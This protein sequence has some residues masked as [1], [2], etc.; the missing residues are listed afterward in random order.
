MSQKTIKIDKGQLEQ[1]L[2]GWFDK[3]ADQI[4]ILRI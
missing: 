2:F 1:A 4:H 3:T